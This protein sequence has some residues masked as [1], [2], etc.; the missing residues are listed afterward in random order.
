ML[1][2]SDFAVSAGGATNTVTD[3]TVSGI[4][5]A[6]A[7]TNA[8]AAGASNVTVSCHRSPNNPHLWSL[9]TPHLD[10]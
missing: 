9:K 10:N 7:L 8:V 2:P 1:A 3:V 4:T 6:L 5:V